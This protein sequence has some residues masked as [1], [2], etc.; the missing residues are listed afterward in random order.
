MPLPTSLW[1]SLP[2]HSRWYLQNQSWIRDHVNLLNDFKVPKPI[3]WK[4]SFSWSYL[5]AI[6]MQDI[7]VFFFCPLFG[8]NA[9]DRILVNQQSAISQFW[10][11]PFFP[12]QKISAL[13]SF[14][15][16]W[17]WCDQ[18]F[19][20]ATVEITGKWNFSF[21]MWV[22]SGFQIYIWSF[23]EFQKDIFDVFRIF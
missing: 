22:L 10:P 6:K 23:I 17:A 16:A 19:F 13:G 12:N 15:A 5:C 8:V 1:L 4:V 18:I 20:K 7:Y 2:W 9:T 14:G 21:M 3:G 11:F